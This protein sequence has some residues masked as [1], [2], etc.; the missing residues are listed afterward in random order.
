MTAAAI[1]LQRSA[2]RAAAGAP[3]TLRELLTSL[4]HHRRAVLA[5]FIIPL[6]LALVAALFARPVYTAESRLLILLG[7]DYVFRSDVTGAP[8]GLSFDRAQIVQAEIQ[9]LGDRDLRAEALKSVGVGRAYPGLER[10]PNGLAVAAARLDKD[11][12]IV[13]VPQSN[14]VDLTLKN[15]SPVVAAELLNTLIERYLVRRRQIFQQTD[16]AQVQQER[17]R[18]RGRLAELETQIS[19]FSAAHGFGDYDQALS[20]A[21]SQKTSLTSQLQNLEQQVAGRRGRTEGLGDQLRDTPPSIEVFAD[22]SRSQQLETLTGALLALQQQRREAAAKY[23]DAYPLVADLDRRIA[24]LQAQI[25]AT[26]PRQVAAERTGANPT[27]QQLD[28]DLAESRGD[29]AGLEQG[30]RETAR[31][32]KAAD[33]Q[34]NDLTR[35][36]PAFREMTRMRALVEAEYAD[37]AK[38][39]EAAQLQDTLSRTQANVRVIQRATIPF[40]G[41]AGRIVTL[42]AGAVLAFACAGATAFLAAALREEMITPRDL[43][44]KLDVPAVLSIALRPRA[45]APEDPLRRTPILS[46]EEAVLLTR[47]GGAARQGAEVI[48]LM[49]AEVGAGVSTLAFDLA[50]QMA[51]GGRRVLLIDVEAEGGAEAPVAQVGD[52]SLFRGRPGGDDRAPV[53][54]V[55]WADVLGRARGAYDVVALDCPPL[56]RSGAALVLAPFVDVTL[57]VIEAEKTRATVARGVIDRIEAAGG[58]IDGAILNKRQFP[59]PAA[60]YDRL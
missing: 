32:L 53:N 22:K 27:R 35:I 5:A 51:H 26:P 43:E 15:R 48:A 39:S 14:V 47:L 56:T 30:R 12:S 49:G 24:G 40:N 20:A 23:T 38:R 17:D 34:L 58:A 52:T 19:A 54:E 45:G 3:L 41:E 46:A 8:Q 1:D 60:I 50:L 21:Q 16:P 36:G 13:N 59:V 4:F 55:Q 28:W 44:R 10:S 7:D 42:A 33:A 2:P 11:L 57:L 29:L 9:I 25:Q 31:E 6:C 18:L 37:V